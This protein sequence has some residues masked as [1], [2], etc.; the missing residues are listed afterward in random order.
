MTVDRGFT[1]LPPLLAVIFGSWFFIGLALC[2][3][4]VR[5]VVVKGG[6]VR[7]AE[8][9]EPDLWVCIGF[10][11]WFLTNIA[12][13][14]SASGADHDVTQRDIIHGAAFFVCIVLA[15]GA[16]LQYRGISPLRQFGILSLNPVTCLG[17]ALAILVSAVPFI[18]FTEWLT[19]IVMHG[20]EEVQNVIEF[21]VNASRKSNTEAIFLMLGLAVLVAPVAEETIFRGYIYGVLKRHIGAIGAACFSSALFAAMH[22]NLSAL[23][24]L[25]VLALF[26]TLA[27]EATGSLLVNIF[28]HAIFNLS[29]LLVTLEVARHP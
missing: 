3:Y 11:L 7:T 15:L 20:R 21:F 23:A 17:A 8:F 25:F 26:L 24:P 12:S 16:F 4:F 18:L 6:K 5:Q 27:Y 13:G 14:F 1:A 9:R 29:M 10:I 22:V 19:S 28:M 2:F